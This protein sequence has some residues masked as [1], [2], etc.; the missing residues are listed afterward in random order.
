MTSPRNYLLILLALTTLG[1]VVLAWNQ[2][3]EIIQLNAA[4]QEKDLDA[5]LHQ[6]DFETKIAALQA[7]ASKKAAKRADEASQN[8]A[9]DQRQRGPFGNMRAMMNDPQFVKLLALQQKA[10]LNGSYAP[11]FKQLVQKLALSPAQIDAFQNLLVQKQ[12]AAR[13]TMI[14]ARDQ[15]LDPRTD[16]AEIGQLV[17]QSNADI[18]QQIQ[19]TLG[20]DGFTQ[21]QNYEQTLP[22]RNTVTLLQQMMSYTSTPIPDQEV[23]P[24]IDALSSNAPKTASNPTSPRA[25]L[26]G[27][28]RTAPITAADIPIISGLTGIP[29]PTL[30]PLLP[31]INAPSK[32]GPLL[33]GG[34]PAGA[35]STTGAQPTGR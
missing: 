3:L 9:N 31:Q 17:A 6:H 7:S 25:L 2:H 35:T 15:G 21:Y 32:F 11:L 24:L 14:A 18:D 26:A 4:L 1:G 12:N 28:N 13:D 5:Q 33:R 8:S 20:P 10:A 23:Q 29:P 16:R 34:T 27:P 19:T 30:E 22:Q